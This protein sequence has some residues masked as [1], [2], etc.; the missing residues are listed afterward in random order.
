MTREGG[1]FRIAGVLL[2][3][4]TLALAAPAMA[5]EAVQRLGAEVWSWRAATQPATGDD[6]PR[7]V[8]PEDW[9]PDWSPAA[10]ADIQARLADFERRWQALGERPRTASEEVDYRLVGSALARVRWELDHI[11]AW[12]RQPAFYIQ[13][14]LGPVFEVLLPPPPLEDARL[15]AVLHLFERVPATL[16]AGEANLTDMRGPFVDA[17]SEQLG[18]VPGSIEGM[19]A[20]LLPLLRPEARPRLEAAR[21]AALA[22]FGSFNAFLDA[23]RNGLPEATAVGTESYEFFLREVALYPWSAREIALRGEQ[24]WSRTVAFETLEQRRNAGL[25]EPAMAATLDEVTARLAAREQEVRD[26]LRERELLTIPEWLGHYH[27]RGFPDYFA[28]VAWLG[29][30]FDLTSPLRLDRNATVYLPEPSPG[31]GYFNRSI[32]IDPRPIIVHEGVPGHYL[33]LALSWAHE[34]PLRRHYYDSGANEGVGFYA[35]EMMLQAGLFEDAPRTRETIYNFA[36]LRALRVD[37]DVK[38]ALGIYSLDEAAEV[39]ASRVP[40]DRTTAREEAVFF[41]ATPGQALS[42][43]IGKLQVLD[44]L[45][46]ARMRAGADFDLRAFHDRL[47]RNGNVPIA[48]QRHEHFAG[49]GG[50]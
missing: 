44:F 29:R 11:A 22:A 21:D 38:L 19:S 46:E 30:T 6:I 37:V 13:Q 23:R 26:F 25:P 5:E 43:Q 27:G 2:L 7:I 20:A 41:S 31:L 14:A 47:W 17:A 42:Y 28:P 36:R 40:M 49:E 8:R 34:N 9:T 45:A 18:A 33:Q 12:K 39:L 50:R 24:E 3:A 1:I 32:A 48:L 4:L 16:A 15:A 10:V 35:E